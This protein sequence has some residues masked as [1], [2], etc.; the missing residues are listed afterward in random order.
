MG[1]ESVELV[2]HVYLAWQAGDLDELLS[3]VDPE[4]SWS[5]VLRFLEGDR[6]AVGHQEL[7]RW[8]RHIRIAYRSLRPLPERFEDHGSR[9]LVLGRLVGAS[10]LEEGDL[11]VPVSWVW[12]VRAGSIVAMQAFL[13]ERA[14]RDALAR[15]W[16]GAVS[17][18][19]AGD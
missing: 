13:E 12:T 3:L 4:V 18:P 7:R 17:T 15:G 6:A 2:R 16:G 1:F 14:A 9:V 5:P 8:F 11:D 10:R 19:V